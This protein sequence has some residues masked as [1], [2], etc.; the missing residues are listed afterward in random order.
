MFSV[1]AKWLLVILAGFA[2][3]PFLSG[4]G[5]LRSDLP[6]MP[7]NPSRYRHAMP[8]PEPPPAATQLPARFRGI[9]RRADCDALDTFRTAFGARRGEDRYFTEADVNQDGV[10][11]GR[12]LVLL[13][14]PYPSSGDCSPVLDPDRF[15]PLDDS[16]RPVEDQFVLAEPDGTLP[17]LEF[18]PCGRSPLGLGQG[19]CIRLPDGGKISGD[20]DQSVIEFESAT[21]FFG[22]AS[23]VKFKEALV[24]PS[25]APSFLPVHGLNCADLASAFGRDP[26]HGLPMELMGFF[27]V[28][29]LRGTLT[30]AGIEGA[31]FVPAAGLP[32]PFASGEY[33][34][35]LVDLNQRDEFRIPFFGSFSIAPLT[36][37]ASP[38]SPLWL[39]LAPGGKVSL[40]GRVDVAA[41]NGIT[42]R[43]DLFLEDPWYRLL[44]W[45][46]EISFPAVS[47]FSGLLK[48]AAVPDAGAVAIDAAGLSEFTGRLR[49][50]AD[51]CRDLG[52]A[53]AA[54]GVTRAA[55]PV[56][57]PS[58]GN[59]DPGLFLRLRQALEPETQDGP[60]SLE[61]IVDRAVADGRAA[62]ASRDLPLLLRFTDALYA[63]RQA[64]ARID[65]I[66]RQAATTAST[67]PPPPNWSGDAVRALPSAIVL[68]AP[69]EAARLAA[70]Y[71]NPLAAR[72]HVSAGSFTA[73]AG[74][75]VLSLSVAEAL[76]RLQDVVTIAQAVAAA[77]GWVAP[78]AAELAGQLASHAFTAL[79]EEMNEAES[80]R[81]SAA[82]S[83]A[84]EL[85]MRLN[86]LVKSPFFPKAPELAP[87]SAAANTADYASRLN[88]ILKA[89]KDR[90]RGEG[91]MANLAAEAGSCVSVIRAVPGRVPWD[92]AAFRPLLDALSARIA[93][94]TTADALNGETSLPALLT[95]VRAGNA[96][97]ELSQSI[98]LEGAEDWYGAR[99]GLVAARI[100][101][102]GRA[103]AAGQQLREAVGILA[104]AADRLGARSFPE[105]RKEALKA[106]ATVL[107]AA[108]DV[109]DAMSEA[110]NARRAALP[111][112]APD[113]VLP[114]GM[115]VR[116]A[117]G[118]LTVNREDASFAASFGGRLVVPRWGL[119]LLITNAS[120]GSGGT[121]VVD[122]R[123]D[124]PLV[125]QGFQV[126]IDSLRFE[127]AGK[128]DS[129]EGAGRLAFDSGESVAVAIRYVEADD[130]LDFASSLSVPAIRFSPDFA[131]F[132]TTIGFSLG[133]GRAGLRLNGT[134]GLFAKEP[135]PE[136]EPGPEDFLLTVTDADLSMNFSETGLDVTLAN[137][138]M[139]L[140]PWVKSVGDCGDGGAAGTGA[141][142]TLSPEQPIRVACANGRTTVTGDIGVSNWMLDG[143]GVDGLKVGICSAT[144]SFV[145][146]KPPSLEDI[147]GSLWLP[148]PTGT[149]RVDVRGIS[150]G[151]DGW[152]QGEI[153]LPPG[154][155]LYSSAGFEFRL[156]GADN[157]AG[158]APATFNMA[159]ADGGMYFELKGGMLVTIPAAALCDGSGGA[160]SM[161]ACGAGVRVGN[162][163]AVITPPSTLTIQ[164]DELA[165]KYVR[166][167]CADGLVFT[168]TT[169]SV[170]DLGNL[171]SLGLDAAV[172]IKVDGIVCF[173]LG[174][175]LTAHDAAFTFAGDVPTFSFGS[176]S[177]VGASFQPAAGVT[178]TLTSVTIENSCTDV[179]VPD[180]LKP[181]CITLSF[182]GSVKLDGIDTEFGIDSATFRPDGSFA[183]NA[184][185]DFT[186][187]GGTQFKGSIALTRTGDA[188]TFNGQGALKLAGDQEFE[189]SMSFDS[190]AEKFSF[191]T[192]ANH[193]KIADDFVLFD[194][195]FGFEIDKT[196]V[197]ITASG[198]A[199]LC[200][201]AHP[202][203]AVSREN[204]HLVVDGVSVE[205][206][207]NAQQQTIELK[208][209]SLCLPAV[210]KT[211]LCGG[212]WSR[213]LPSVGLTSES[214]IAVTCRFAERSVDFSAAGGLQFKDIGVDAGGGLVIEIC[215]ATL[216]IPPSGVPS[217]KVVRA[218]ASLPV[219]DKAVKLAL[220]DC[221]IGM[222]G[223][224]TF[225]IGLAD[226]VKLWEEPSGI[227]ITALA[228]DSL[229]QPAT[230]VSWDGPKVTFNGM[231]KVSMTEDILCDAFTGKDVALTA[232]GHFTILPG[233]PPD[234]GFDG[235]FVEG[236][237]RFGGKDKGL[238]ITGTEPGKKA[239]FSVENIGNL[240]ASGSVAPCR[241]SLDGEFGL[242]GL[243]TFRLDE[244]RF[245]CNGGK[246]RFEMGG[247]GIGNFP[248]LALADNLS[249]EVKTVDLHFADRSRE[250]PDLI[251]PDNLELV[252]SGKLKAAFIPERSS[253]EGSGSGDDSGGTDG[254]FP[255]LPTPEGE[256]WIH[257]F[258]V[259]FD[260][261]GDFHIALRG[262]MVVL[263]NVP[264]PPLIVSGGLAFNGLDFAK[265]EDGFLFSDWLIGGKVGVK[266][267]AEE[268]GVGGTLVINRN[269]ILGLCLELPTVV[270]LVVV[271]LVNAKGGLSL[272]GIYHDPCDFTEL[273]EIGTDAEGEFIRYKD[274]QA[275]DKALSW[276][277]GS[278][279]TTT[280]DTHVEAD[281]RAGA[282]AEQAET[283]V[284][285][286]PPDE[287]TGE[288]TLL[289][290]LTALA[291]L[292]P[293]SKCMCDPV[294]FKQCPPP[295]VCIWCQPHPNQE[296]YPD[297]VIL[298]GT[299]LD[300]KW[301][302][303]NVDWLDL[304]PASPIWGQTPAKISDD[305][306]RGVRDAVVATWPEPQPDAYGPAYETVH[307]FW[308]QM[309]EE[310]RLQM[311][312]ALCSALSVP[313]NGD[314]NSSAYD[315]VTN[316]LHEGLMCP[317]PV[318]KLSG[319][320]TSLAFL[321]GLVTLEGGITAGGLVVPDIFGVSGKLGVMGLTV[322]DASGFLMLSDINGDPNPSMCGEMNTKV[323]FVELGRARFGYRCDGCFS[324]A[325]GEDIQAMLDCLPDETL[326][327]IL[328][329]L[330]KWK[331]GIPFVDEA[332]DV[333]LC[334]VKTG[335]LAALMYSPA[336]T[337][338]A[339][340][341]KRCF[342]NGFARLY[343]H[344]NPYLYACS[345]DDL[346]VYGIPVGGFTSSELLLTKEDVA[347]MGS[348]APD[349]LLARLLFG[350]YPLLPF[351]LPEISRGW[352]G[353]SARLPDPVPLMEEALA[354]GVPPMLYLP[355]RLTLET[356]STLLKDLTVVAGF[357]L[358]PFGIRLRRLVGRGCSP[359]F[360]DHPAFR[361]AS[362]AWKP[363]EERENSQYPS[364]RDVL[365]RA[366]DQGQLGNALWKG[367]PDDLQALFP[368]VANM[369][370]DFRR[371]Y[372]PHGGFMGAGADTLPRILTES[373]LDT[374]DNFSMV[375]DESRSW[376]DRLWRAQDFV[377]N[378]I[379]GS[380][381]VGAIAI[382]I[383]APN[384]PAVTDKDGNPRPV[385]D[386]LTELN[387]F[388]WENITVP[389][390]YALDRLF[391]SGTFNAKLLGLELALGTF[392]VVPGT[393]D[394]AGYAV[395][396]G[397]LGKGWVTNFIGTQS[398]KFEVRDPP[399]RTIEERFSELTNQL[400][401]ARAPARRQPAV[402]AFVDSLA[403]GLPKVSFEYSGQPP[404]ALGG[405][406][407]AL[408][409]FD[410]GGL[411]VYAYSLRF[412]PEFDPQ[413]HG[414]YATV[415]RNGGY[416]LCVSN[417]T[418]MPL[419]NA[420][421]GLCQV[422]DAQ[423]AVYPN[424]DAF[425]ALKGYFNVP[426]LELLPDWGLHDVVFE[427]D[428][429]AAAGQNYFYTTGGLDRITFGDVFQIVPM[430]DPGGLLNGAFRVYND[431]GQQMSVLVGAARIQSGILEDANI[432][433]HGA[434]GTNE[435]FSYST[436]GRWGAEVTVDGLFSLRAGTT[437]VARVLRPDGKS[438]DATIE[439]Q[440]RVS[441]SLSMT[442]PLG[443]VITFFPDVRGL[444]HSVTLGDDTGE[445]SLSVSS[446]G[447][448]TLTLSSKECFRIAGDVFQ[449][450]PAE[451]RSMGFSA[452]EWGLRIEGQPSF[453][454]RLPGVMDGEKDS[455]SLFTIDTL[456][457]GT[458]GTFDAAVSN[459]SFG[460][461]NLLEVTSAN[462]RLQRANDVTRF[463]MASP[464]V[465]FF[466]RTT[467]SKTYDSGFTNLLVESTGRFVLDSPNRELDIFGAVIAKGDLRMGYEPNR[468]VT[469]RA[470]AD[471]RPIDFGRV[472]VGATA[473]AELKVT[474]DGDLG[475]NV[476]AAS[477]DPQIFPVKPFSLRVAAKGTNT[478]LIG[479]A[480]KS[481]G[482]FS[483]DV[484]ITGSAN[485]FAATV[486]V[487]G[488]AY[489]R[490]A[491]AVSHKSMTFTTVVVNAKVTGASQKLTVGNIGDADIVVTNVSVTG[492]FACG[493]PVPFTLKP[494]ASK[495]LTV[496]FAPTAVGANLTGALAIRTDAFVSPVNVALSGCAVAAGSGQ[497][498][499]DGL[500]WDIYDLVM[501]DERHGWA[502]VDDGVLETWD[503]CVSWEHTKL[504]DGGLRTIAFEAPP[505]D[506]V[507]SLQFEEPRGWMT[508][509]DSSGNGNHFRVR[510]PDGS[511]MASAMGHT[512][513]G[514]YFDGANDAIEGPGFAVGDNF[515]FSLWYNLLASG[516]NAVFLAC[517][518]MER[519]MLP[520]PVEATRLRFGVF[521]QKLEIQLKSDP[522][523]RY[524][525]SVSPPS[526]ATLF[527][528][529]L[530][531]GTLLG[532]GAELP[533]PSLEMPQWHHVAVVGAKQGDT[534]THVAIYLDGAE[535]GSADLPA[536]VTPISPVRWTVGAQYQAGSE[537]FTNF[538]GGFLDDVRVFDRALTVA[539]IEQLHARPPRGVVAGLEGQVFLTGNGGGSWQRVTDPLASAPVL[540]WK[541]VAL[542]GAGVV[543]LAGGAQ[544]PQAAS[545]V[546]CILRETAG[547]YA[548]PGGTITGSGFLNDVV[549]RGALGLAVGDNAMSFRS[550]D[551]GASWIAV[552]GASGVNLNACD[553]IAV[554]S[555]SSGLAVGTGGRAYGGG[556]SE[557]WA[558]LNSGTTNDLSDIACVGTQPF[559]V[560]RNG[561]YQTGFDGRSAQTVG[562][563]RDLTVVAA[564]AGSASTSVWACGSGGFVYRNRANP[565]ALPMLGVKVSSID[566]GIAEAGL[567]VLRE[568]S[569][570]NSGESTL[571]IT[572]LA[573]NSV[574]FA[575]VADLPL[576][577]EP[578][579]S[580]P[581]RVA[582]VPTREGAVFRA[583]LEI[584]S[585][586]PAGPFRVD[587][588]GSAES[589]TWRA[590]ALAGPAVEDIHFLS[591]YNGF[592]AA[593]TNIFKTVDR[594]ET[595][596]VVPLAL[597]TDANLKAIWFADDK[598]GWACG[599]NAI[600][601]T[602]DAG[603]SWAG[604]AGGF[605]NTVRDIQV[606]RQGESLQGLAV[607]QKEGLP[608][609]ATEYGDVMIR[610]P[611]VNLPSGGQFWSLSAIQYWLHTPAVQMPAERFSGRCCWIFD[612]NDIAVSC[613][614]VLYR[615]VDD[616]WSKWL[617]FPLGR[618]IQ[619]VF[620]LNEWLGWAVGE[621]G[622]FRLLY[623]LAGWSAPA[624]DTVFGGQ[625][626]TDVWFAD[627]TNGWAVGGPRPYRAYRTADGGRR[628]SVCYE[629]PS[630]ARVTD[631]FGTSKSNV[632]LAGSVGESGA[633]WRLGHAEPKV[634][635]ALVA[636]AAHDWGVVELNATN[637]AAILL[638][639]AGAV[640]VRVSKPYVAGGAGFFEVARYTE[641]IAA[642][643]S[644]VVVVKFRAKRAGSHAATLYVLS[645]GCV[646]V[647][648]T[649][650]RALVPD[651]PHLVPITTQ[652]PG[653]KVFVNN[654]AYTTPVH[655]AVMDSAPTG[656]L[657][658][659]NGVATN[660]IRIQKNQTLN[661]T[662]YVAKEIAGTNMWEAAIPASV[663]LKPIRFDFNADRPALTC[664][665]QAAAG[666]RGDEAPPGAYLRLKNASITAPILGNCAATGHVFV[667][668]REFE[669]TLQARAFHLP[670]DNALDGLY[671]L[672][673]S[674]ASWYA[675]GKRE[676][677]ELHLESLSPSVQVLNQSVVPATEMTFDVHPD[678]T[679]CGS[680]STL[681]DLALIR[682]VFEMGPGSVTIGNGCVGHADAWHLSVDSRALLLRQEDGDW[683][684]DQPFGFAVTEAKQFHIP[685]PLP[686]PL[687]KLPA[688]GSFLTLTNGQAY[689]DRDEAGVFS[690][691]LE[692]YAVDLLGTRVANGGGCSVGT[693]GTMEFQ[694]SAVKDA[695]PQLGDGFA[696]QLHDGQIGFSYNPF[697]PRLALELPEFT[698]TK[699]SAD[700]VDIPGLSFDSAGDFDTGELP[701]PAGSFDGLD[702]GKPSGD[703]GDDYLQLS[704]TDGVL[705]LKI[706]DNQ[707]VFEGDMRLA[708]DAESDGDIWGSCSGHLKFLMIDLG[709][710]S[711]GYNSDS[712]CRFYSHTWIN[713]CT[714]MSFSLGP[715]CLRGCAWVAG[716]GSCIGQCVSCPE[717]EE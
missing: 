372:F 601:V 629:V 323:M 417:V 270:P 352:I 645:D 337:S 309:T 269:G 581:I 521:D 714:E 131:V 88:E 17:P 218:E 313:A 455:V 394:T 406:L 178:I 478:F 531:L 484:V 130:S 575:A 74:S 252:L 224:P 210:F 715:G 43:A 137:G 480:P 266:I 654:I 495:V 282:P 133:G 477:G 430:D 347:F 574:Y 572:N 293:E 613:S 60:L 697:E 457:I 608:S 401:N 393:P 565:D 106:A 612:T 390:L 23:P 487:T 35:Y 610:L 87:L 659:R 182:S 583:A 369:T 398:L 229:G 547:G 340:D 159:R 149:Q 140:P 189:G 562:G 690:L 21:A 577:L 37:S 436:T 377:T 142:I 29:W 415:R 410:N 70:G 56:N 11:D 171:F 316:L 616:T 329:D 51:A 441:A 698:L 143:F 107:G 537:S 353:G 469:I 684:V 424:A 190:A 364:R 124:A 458:D 198:S 236:T 419:V 251:Y 446:D 485:S 138:T 561:T 674:E 237:F 553:I 261:N 239:R 351:V 544:Q 358:H 338:L 379:F 685:I 357:E 627:A 468:S 76:D 385:G 228:K 428:S 501:L 600:V 504:T 450:C 82:F 134:A 101:A 258:K 48:A 92:G 116:E 105:M 672:Q 382:Y 341:Q 584:Q 516:T 420:P 91:S 404:A 576:L 6:P 693:S 536:T 505:A 249:L 44:I 632:W 226:D 433:I 542:N 416:A 614:N 336:F 486:P 242:E 193:L 305:V 326:Q 118:S 514:A 2:A 325:C 350:N 7:P 648:A 700:V 36:L 500:G 207:A 579:E 345:D 20:G 185:A 16:D 241:F 301:V 335:V 1:R 701:L 57:P 386:L 332:G 679:F 464:A 492:P 141:Q 277:A 442:I 539:E 154:V 303:E 285:A 671:L 262:A 587:L 541:G 494:L 208:S 129:A 50:M 319:T 447:R 622:C 146:G 578:G 502:A 238:L 209:G 448:F 328:A 598:R 465:T 462:M 652:P 426:Y 688:D 710:F 550:T 437:V 265:P 104:D 434:G 235:L 496:T 380:S 157:P 192:T 425:P 144:L 637:A 644:G 53:N 476:R 432:L 557:S 187:E 421:D 655:V 273:V 222:N 665:P 568:V 220:T 30:D 40:K 402:N 371:D 72:L 183:I 78:P 230:T 330:Q 712:D 102:V 429:S 396:Q 620:F 366:L 64:D 605:T 431:N 522:R 201:V 65:E 524:T 680:F 667:N 304:E 63:H 400:A 566:F 320:I 375:L 412:Q 354:N 197:K 67:R 205:F 95:L 651:T 167:G 397:T 625:A 200:A 148:L 588:L 121:F 98:G 520:P 427:F 717:P 283:Q 559:A 61:K 259:G 164:T 641:E 381:N 160:I 49:K 45:S 168:N 227:R 213:D 3:L 89:G 216:Q 456:E 68:A 234:F 315:V 545:V 481:A 703:D 359:Y 696:F 582:F 507:L 356:E 660:R 594:G 663:K 367:T 633:V 643:Q 32:L 199:G 512:G 528:L 483:N 248:E 225:T 5:T 85:M 212:D 543:V 13:L 675:L 699:G 247:A 403:K 299:S 513:G 202:L 126:F 73:P 409:R 449:L 506:A 668:S 55:I 686:N 195:G 355:G 294:A 331:E 580:R 79:Q 498:V 621:G 713:D 376:S 246:S 139:H 245:V 27:E 383:P 175:S 204:F 491:L 590:V 151:L 31:V 272:A 349:K 250:L 538:L 112:P 314:A 343:E 649:E 707:P 96:W 619:E 444:A 497:V 296:K 281:A 443:A 370:L 109:C 120:L 263:N 361:P 405:A 59:Q 646:G 636:S 373:P 240:F 691:G 657:Q 119:D 519:P 669:A 564:V 466:P 84:V 206:D 291:D 378:Y 624:D 470:G 650:L 503:G 271:D 472:A 678:K 392:D 26:A 473:C 493:V 289:D 162:G 196:A 117:R 511:P 683:L 388:S 479:F 203:P 288:R 24:K 439:G 113:M 135:Q 214:R 488:E 461:S 219:M 411:S 515:T 664:P 77:G 413:N 215:D 19:L 362:N 374:W 548:V 150:W 170:I 571:V 41:A 274:D 260:E 25:G 490:P 298:K 22:E 311:S 391:F 322:G 387:D 414:V 318:V 161:S 604:E 534:S 593:G 33:L 254:E 653:L 180:C 243:V 567:P 231:L 223:A 395:V 677:F 554:G 642:G 535:A 292:L 169:I 339:D 615:K 631:V 153:S 635:N 482:R 46:D 334:P 14:V 86:G 152:R 518:S 221:E 445:A 452:G 666:I 711:V 682:N 570:R 317:R 540:H 599:K 54:A 709:G 708:L 460:V 348:C 509:A 276:N 399:D 611:T 184:S 705:H 617:E 217:L 39:T 467:Y 422:K 297:R 275:R 115:H 344:F 38:E 546:P 569:V 529:T 368:E 66:L 99:L 475:L 177:V 363:P 346:K 640:P 694:A 591:A 114:G 573:V 673:V 560:G 556:V 692:N 526:G 474:N 499:Q 244:W 606:C 75:P 689:L 71:V 702:I 132:N 256:V 163:P 389:E 173:P 658:W 607:S 533:H 28:S 308:V 278:G 517:N 306:S 8:E 186:P 603:D 440:G 333:V 585:N 264:V 12:D 302:Q 232:G 595:W 267:I 628:W 423:F 647:Q 451:D 233:G 384:P 706:R 34:Q 634:T 147:E 100:A 9:E 324:E 638:R 166:L 471:A 555:G 10:V 4:C 108:K 459:G 81:D 626:L 300:V 321:A 438:F 122:A 280:P 47:G 489:G 453:V 463:Q 670:T 103:Q 42:L 597:P 365:F 687:V 179:A 310:V 630:G 618:D 592:A 435:P 508:F 676:P 174:P 609:G 123:T 596:Q 656:P 290:L 530:P 307:D 586:D 128:L 360:D 418:L 523:F 589:W 563:G 257:R 111:E 695:T 408:I 268:I 623:G 158:C 527:G 558:G 127:G 97:E 510:T 295:T 69:G 407:P 662:R 156:M 62:I 327:K 188:F 94:A 194:A 136:G 255:S 342:L 287:E 93:A 155:P 211:K 525:F 125:F 253:G 58:P 83:Q 279:G 552:G 716:I 284:P 165:G 110:E 551:G 681:D 549:F 532:G 661:G 172:K 286:P 52:A 90:A 602:A 191:N 18:R 176:L 312:N 15:V 181:E 454:V 704:R 145:E 80:R 639:N